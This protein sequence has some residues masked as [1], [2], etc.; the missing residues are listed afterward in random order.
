MSSW[1]PNEAKLCV[2]IFG[3]QLSMASRRQTTAQIK[4]NLLV[5]FGPLVV[6]VVDQWVPFGGAKSRCATWWGPEL[7]LVTDGACG[8]K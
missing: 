3:V 2:F 5:F 1:L 6:V 7:D 4:R 8:A